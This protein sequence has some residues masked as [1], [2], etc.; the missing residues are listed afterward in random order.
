MSNNSD[1]EDDEDPPPVTK[2]LKR[3][4]QPASKVAGSRRSATDPKGKGKQK[5]ING[6]VASGSGTKKRKATTPAS[7]LDAK[8]PRG[9]ASGA[10][11]YLKDDIDALMDILEEQLPLGGWAWNS[12]SDEFNAWAEGNG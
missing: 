5:A 12:A 4:S 1:S 9:C 10:A 2:L 7:Q 3:I 11:N 6:P 8:K